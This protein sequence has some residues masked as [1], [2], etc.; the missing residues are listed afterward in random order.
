MES[1]PTQGTLG[2]M[3]LGI[4]VTDI[5]GNRITFEQAAKRYIS[6]SLSYLTA[7]FGFFMAGVTDKKQTLHDKISNSL[8]IRK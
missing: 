4:A 6:K 2:K 3:L 7:C 5:N 8:V 1:S